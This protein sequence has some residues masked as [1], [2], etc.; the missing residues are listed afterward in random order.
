MV[1][2]TKPCQSAQC[3][4]NRMHIYKYRSK[5]DKHQLKSIISLFRRQEKISNQSIHFASLT[6]ANNF[7]IRRLCICEF[8]VRAAPSTLQI[9]NIRGNPRQKCISSTSR[10]RRMEAKIFRVK[11][12]PGQ[13]IFKTFQS[14]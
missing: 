4:N 9:N 11:S 8:R 5:T 2:T 3:K 7:C 13:Q 12:T 6:L 14:R 10:S 1:Q